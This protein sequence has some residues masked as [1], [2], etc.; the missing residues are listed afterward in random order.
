MNR[1]AEAVTIR[2]PATANLML[3]SA[4]RAPANYPSP[5]DFSIQR[6][7]SILNGFFTRIGTTEQVLEWD[8]PNIQDGNRLLSVDISGTPPIIINVGFQRCYSTAANALNFLIKTVNDVSGTSNFYFTLDISGSVYN[9]VGRDLSN[10]LYP[11]RL[12]DSVLAR[13]LTLY[14]DDAYYTSYRTAREIVAPDLRIYRYIDFVSAP[15]TYNQD[16]KDASTQKFVVDVLARWYFADDSTD[17]NDYD[18]Y[19]FPIY[20][21]YAPFVMRRIFNPPKQIRWDRIQPIGQLTFSVYGKKF[22]QAPAA[23]DYK[24]MGT[25][26]ELRYFNTNWLMTLQISED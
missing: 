5:F 23:Y 26:K 12:Y 13:Q 25:D 4:D 15:L 7:N 14:G 1:G 6:P 2:Y 20:M 22:P 3:D 11:W 8:T 9:L 18:Q 21:G 10:N 19:G 16:L 24:N 17:T